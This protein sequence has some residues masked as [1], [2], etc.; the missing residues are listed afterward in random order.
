MN[1]KTKIRYLDY[2][3]VILLIILTSRDSFHFLFSGNMRNF[4]LCIVYTYFFWRI[5]I[6]Y[7]FEKGY[8]YWSK[9]ILALLILL[10]S[11]SLWSGNIIESLQLVLI[12]LVLPAMVIMFFG[13]RYS[14]T[15]V[16]KTIFVAGAFMT[17]MSY[18]L[19]FIM[20]GLGITTSGSHSGLWRGI[21]THKNLLSVSSSFHFIISVYLIF[22]EKRFLLRLIFV[23]FA[24][25]EVCLVVFSGS[26][27]GIVVILATL[28]ISILLFSINKIKNHYLLASIIS[29]VFIFTGLLVFILISSIDNIAYAFGKDLTFSGR[30][31]IW[32]GTLHMIN[33]RP[34]FGFGYGSFWE[35]GSYTY[36]FVNQYLNA[37]FFEFEHAHNGF[38]DILTNIGYAG[39]LIVLV[40]YFLFIKRNLY[41]LFK[42]TEKNKWFYLPMIYLVFFTIYNMQESYF[43]QQNFIM[44]TFFVYFYHFLAAETKTKTINDKTMI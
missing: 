2:C 8:I 6:V 31:L 27:T 15:T 34:I 38:L 20:P 43:L 13:N 17:F 29:F 5:M 9:L 21:F 32:E 14:F 16:I 22:I 24:I 26:S 4:T 3:F 1:N 35:K 33:E 36:N 41:F 44:W 18:M 7:V 19:V 10:I 28:F 25:L 42:K 39:L 40:A 12:Q 37:V 11:S 23:F 30:T